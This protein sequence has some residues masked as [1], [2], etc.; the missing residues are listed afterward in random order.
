MK[1]K[2]KIKIIVSF[3]I[4]LMFL[5]AFR[6]GYSLYFHHKIVKLAHLPGYEE[7]DGGY[8]CQKNDMIYF[9]AVQ[10]W[11]KLASNAD[12]SKRATAD[13][14]GF[15]ATVH[16]YPFVGP[17]NLRINLQYYDDM[18]NLTYFHVE[19]DKYCKLAEDNPSALT[20]ELYDKYKDKIEEIYNL[21][22]Q[23][24]GFYE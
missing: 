12:I 1:K 13:E 20:L 18:M 3:F 2:T 11:W 14:P 7:I 17:D 21:F 15:I 22:K 19:V 8:I 24:W 9:I 5:V 23:E 6:I 4:L 16:I 10:K